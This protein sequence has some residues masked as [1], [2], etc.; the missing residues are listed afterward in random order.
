MAEHSLQTN[1]IETDSNK[2]PKELVKDD[3]V[4]DYLRKL[5][6]WDGVPRLDQEANHAGA[7]DRSDEDT[8]NNESEHEIGV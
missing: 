6:A 8:L 4:C 3:P 7:W 1:E 2:G 5:P